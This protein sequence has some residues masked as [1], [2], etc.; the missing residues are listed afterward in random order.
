MKKLQTTAQSTSRAFQHSSINKM[1]TPFLFVFFLLGFLNVGVAQTCPPPPGAGCDE[2]DRSIEF[3]LAS[4][5]GGKEDDCLVRIPYTER[6]CLA[7]QSGFDIF[8]IKMDEKDWLNF[9]PTS[10]CG[11]AYF[12]YKNSIAT[13][14]TTDIDKFDIKMQL[15]FSEAALF[16]SANLHFIKNPKTFKCPSTFLTGKFFF[17][18]CAVSCM[19]WEEV[20]SGNPENPISL[21]H[22]KTT[23]IPCGANCCTST[24]RFC[25]DTDGKVTS[26]PP[27]FAS[28]GTCNKGAVVQGC[29]KKWGYFGKT[30]CISACDFDPAGLKA[31]VISQDDISSIDVNSKVGVSTIKVNIQNNST[32]KII[33]VGFINSFKGSISLFDTSGKQIFA[34]NTDAENGD[35]LQFETNNLSAGIYLLSLQNEQ[36]SIVTEKILIK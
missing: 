8:G 22:L 33:S 34:T 29:Q 15:L 36:N 2:I 9:D 6:T 18:A 7:N 32:T 27:V 1:L 11:K 30:N 26:F 25:E 19:R 17:G 5:W 12:K 20:L 4:L 13:Q 24:Q 31:A 14:S 10:D 23:R 16:N 28:D 21:F 35:Y 3:N